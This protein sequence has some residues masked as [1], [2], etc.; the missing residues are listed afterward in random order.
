MVVLYPLASLLAGLRG[1]HPYRD[2]VFEREARAAER[3]PARA[4]SSQ[5]AGG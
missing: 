5:S 4:A 1:G 3:A 2:N